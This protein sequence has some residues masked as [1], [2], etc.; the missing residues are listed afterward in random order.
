[1]TTVSSTKKGFAQ[2]KFLSEATSNFLEVGRSYK[3]TTN[4]LAKKL[5]KMYKTNPLNITIFLGISASEKL[6]Y[7]KIIR[8]ISTNHLLQNEFNDK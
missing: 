6:T 3:L 7:N 8:L 5:W 1:M 4:E 2:K